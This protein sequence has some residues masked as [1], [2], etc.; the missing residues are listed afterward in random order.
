MNYAPITS[1]KLLGRIL[2]RWF[3]LVRFS[4]LRKAIKSKLLG[5]GD[6]RDDPFTSQKPIELN[7][8]ALA[9]WWWRRVRRHQKQEVNR[10]VRRVKTPAPTTP[11][12]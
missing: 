4:R 2:G 5:A 7:N 12:A 1:Q 3:F 9:V 6:S 10:D 8:W 11:R